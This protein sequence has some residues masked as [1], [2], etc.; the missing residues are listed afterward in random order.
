MR[1][2]RTGEKWSVRTDGVPGTVVMIFFLSLAASAHA[3]G[4]PNI[5]IVIADDATFHELPLYGGKNFQTPNL[6]RLASEGLVFRRAYVSMSM[7]TTCR[8]ELYTGMYPV[9]SGACWNHSAAKTG[10]LSIAHHLGRLGYRVGLAGK[11]HIRPKSVFPFEMVDGFERRCVAQTADHDCRGIQEF[12]SRD[13]KQPFCLVVALV[14]PHIPWTVGDPS[15]F[16]SSKFVLPP[17]LIDTPETREALA[18]YY[19]EFEVMDQQLGD[20]LETLRA[21]GQQ[22]ET[23]VLF[24]SEQ[25]G[26]WPGC[27]WTNWEEGLHTALVA[28]WPGRI[29]PGTQTEALV[30]YAD[31]L[32]TLVAAAGAK[33]SPNDFDGMSFMRVL[34][35]RS[36]KHRD[37]AYAMHNNLPEGPPYPIR[38]VHDGRFHYIRNLC[39]DRLYV[40][41]HVMGKNEHGRYWLSWM[42]KMESDPHAVDMVTRY[43]RRPK[44]HLYDTVADPMEMHNLA[45][46]PHLAEIKTRLSAELDRWMKEQGDPGAELDTKARQHPNPTRKNRKVGT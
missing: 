39:P 11:T 16:D 34:L 12:M 46:D 29:Q 9:R 23:L 28:R 42:W 36:Q 35:G 17:Y 25:G 1:K 4:Q 44:E 37:Y 45:D 33:P 32:P 5:L 26:Q 18:R 30:Q 38:A 41:K 27:K 2:C 24:T 3:A 15:H 31:V 14:V 7:C 10:T 43:M 40:E 8:T 20:I 6:D 22:D 19:A 13:E 21:T